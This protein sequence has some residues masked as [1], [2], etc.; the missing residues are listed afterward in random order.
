M[1]EIL[2]GMVWEA[3]HV[4][5]ALPEHGLNWLILVP[6]DTYNARSERWH[7]ASLRK[8]KLVC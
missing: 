8:L 2:P 6:E 7:Y 3:S 4:S 1:G 5:H